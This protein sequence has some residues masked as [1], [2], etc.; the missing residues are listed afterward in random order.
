MRADVFKLERSHGA[1]LYAAIDSNGRCWLAD[2]KGPWV[3]AGASST[4][5]ELTRAGYKF[6]HTTELGGTHTEEP[7]SA[8]AAAATPARRGRKS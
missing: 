2:H 4:R 3:N 7:I 1:P 8:P 5:E 6:V